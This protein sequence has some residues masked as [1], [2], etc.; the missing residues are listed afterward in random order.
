LLA[1]SSFTSFYPH[2]HRATDVPAE[3]GE[4]V[5]AECARIATSWLV[6]GEPGFQRMADAI[7]PVRIPF[8]GFAAALPALFAA[9]RRPGGWIGKAGLF[10][11]LA[12][13]L[14]SWRSAIVAATL[15]LW[16]WPAAAGRSAARRLAVAAVAA[17]PGAVVVATLGAVVAIYGADVIRPWSAWPLAQVALVAAGTVAAYPGAPRLEPAPREAA[18]SSSAGPLCPA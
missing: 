2:Y 13:F 12:A 5:L 9:R 11:L 14:L 7:D 8:L 18:V 6:F 16:L 10:V 4:D 15:P 17:L 3:L 1:T